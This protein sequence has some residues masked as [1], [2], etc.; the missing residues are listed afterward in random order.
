MISLYEKDATTFADNGLCVLSPSRCSV[1]EIA[2]GSY[3]LQMEHPLDENGKYQ[4]LTEERLIKAPVPKTIIPETVMPGMTVWDTNKQ[5]N[6]YSKIPSVHS[7][8]NHQ[9][10]QTAY[11]N[12]QGWGYATN[13][14][15]N[16]GAYVVYPVNQ[17]TGVLYRAKISGYNMPA[18]P[19]DYYWSYIGKLS[20]R[21]PTVD[22]GTV[23]VQLA[24]GTRVY[25]MAIV[26][27]GYVKVQVQGSG[28]IGFV[29]KDDLTDAGSTHDETIPQQTITEQVFRIYE[30]SCDEETN[31]CTV[32]ARHMSYDFRRNMLQ[33]CKV[34]EVSPNE[35]IAAIQCALVENDERI[36]ACN[37]TEGTV[38]QDWSFMN[39]I[40]AL[41][42]PESGLVEKL[43]AALIRNNQDFF[44]LQRAEYG[45]SGFTIEYGVNLRGVKWTRNIENVATR[46]IPRS[47]TSDKGYLYISDGGQISNGAVQNQS[48]NYVESENADHFASP[49][50]YDLNCS[51]QVGQEYETPAGDKVKYDEATVLAKMKTDALEMF[52]KKH[53]DA[54]GISLDVDFILLGDTEEFQQYRNL[55]RINLYDTIRI[56]TGKSG[57]ETEARV[58]E[59]DYDCLL[60]RYN[61]I[62]LGTVN[63]FKHRVPGYR[64]INKSITYDKLS[65][66]LI[67]RILTSD[68]SSS[69]DRGEGGTRTRGDEEYI[70]VPNT[71]VDAG[72]VAAGGDF[73]NMVW[74]TNGNGKP[75]WHSLSDL[76]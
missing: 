28:K 43:E 5:T 63:E 72:I 36:I 47:G 46:V 52:T 13:A 44:L 17:T 16:A 62:R 60:G 37:I 7:N 42:D 70:V 14:Y 8:P 18:P 56:R 67:N 40:N 1:T 38:T 2:G 15:Y 29:L 9:L 27:G 33:Q 50:L 75:G 23:I 20:D 30:V 31:M 53:V 76:S 24:S 11:N 73:P 71:E 48:K 68:R 57:I 54:V 39:P 6:L 51:Y 21:N 25:K 26:S 66:D 74:A 41:M 32:R 61:A 34:T 12:Y 22:P 65:P 59:Y 49:I 58:T 3:E 69:T 55:Q 45:S 64:M 10:L 19:S 35:A 4:Q